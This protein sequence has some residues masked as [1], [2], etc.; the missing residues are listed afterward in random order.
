MHDLVIRGGNVVDGTGAPARTAD[1]A[2]TDGRIT[3]V[4]RVDGPARQ[5]VEADGLAVTP[6]WVD[7]HTHYDGQVTW[8]PQVTPS[9]WHGVTTVVMGNCGVGFA[10]ARP[11]AHDFLIELMEGVEDIPGTALHDGMSWQWESFPEYLDAL[12]RTDRVLDIA[13]QVP[14]AALRAYVLGERAHEDA[15]A[16]EVAVMARLTRE[17]L[18]AGAAGFSTSRTILHRS[19][20]GL[21]PGTTAPIDELLAIGDAVGEAGHGV[22]QLIDDGS[23]VGE[24]GRWMAEIARRSGATVTYSLAQA[25]P[26]PLAY[27]EAL[28]SAATAAD[29]GLRIVPQVPCRPTG[30]M[31]GLQSSLH[32]FIT[33]P[34]Y[35][36]LADL[37]LDERVA[38]LRSAEVRD[39]LLSEEPSTGNPIARYLMA[40]WARIFPL[41][42]PPDY[43]PAPETSA[44][45]VATRESRLPEEVVLDWMLE[46]DGRAFLFAPLASY[47]DTNLEAVK[48]MMLHPNAVLGLSDG[49]AHCGLIC[50]VSMPTTLLTHWVRDRSRGE[51]IPLEL[52]VHLQSGRTAEVYGFTDRGTLEPGK[53]ADVNLVDLEGMRLHA[54]EMIFDLPA[55]G[56]RLVQRVDGYRATFVAGQQTYADGQ[57]TGATPGRLV[58]FGS[59]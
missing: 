25:G 4:G 20:H 59:R 35:R 33:H 5:E 17:A 36:A 28:A 32:P 37:P 26:D 18:A 57:P 39:A 58:R 7:I 48:E 31:F 45:A 12:E 38:R 24:V 55:G 42:D 52:A 30:M 11:D 19:K 14:H 51:R 27:R 29:E 54:P 44:A 6:G 13:A 3:E 47:E 9:S 41:G 21:V 40:R 43:E 8:D 16:D 15:T 22:F 50:D 56:R 49:G 2:I 1:V 53:R 23:P 46:R 34:T 10:P